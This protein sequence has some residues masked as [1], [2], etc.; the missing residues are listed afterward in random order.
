MNIEKPGRIYYDSAC[1]ARWKSRTIF[2][3]VKHWDNRSM[4]QRQGLHIRKRLGSQQS[5]TIFQ[6][7]RQT[8]GC[9][10]DAAITQK[11][12][13]SSLLRKQ[14]ICPRFSFRKELI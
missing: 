6:I 8:L 9:L 4:R 14:F 11:G 12:L 5:R 1:Q 3:I 10:F 2:Q 7:V 13:E